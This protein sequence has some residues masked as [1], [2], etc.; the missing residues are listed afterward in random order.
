[1]KR[2]RSSDDDV[3]GVVGLIIIVVVIIVVFMVALIG[4]TVRESPAVY[5]ERGFTKTHSARVL[6]T[7]LAGLAS[8]WVVAALLV[9]IPS[10]RSIGIHLAAWSFLFWVVT[11]VSIDQYHRKKEPQPELTLN[12]VLLPWHSEPEPLDTLQ[13]NTQSNQYEPIHF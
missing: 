2:Y 5:Q 3:A 4:A 13:Q 8:A 6:W 1:M 7:A 12:D 10:L 11:V 9:M